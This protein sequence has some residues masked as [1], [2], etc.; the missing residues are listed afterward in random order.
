MGLR[1]WLYRNFVRMLRL[2]GQF[3]SGRKP[4]ILSAIAAPEALPPLVIHIVPSF[5]VGGTGQLVLDLV[6]A[7][8]TFSQENSYDSVSLQD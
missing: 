7:G 4:S 5:E 3:R 8:I 1:G 2:I 6:S